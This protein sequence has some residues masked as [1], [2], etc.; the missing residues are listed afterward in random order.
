MVLLTLVVV[1][2][3]SL[4]GFTSIKI[5]K[6]L[7]NTNTYVN[8]ICITPSQAKPKPSQTQ[9]KPIQAKPSQAKAKDKAKAKAKAK[10][11]VKAKPKP[12]QKPSQSQTKAMPKAKPKPN[13]AKSSQSVNRGTLTCASRQSTSPCLLGIPALDRIARLSNRQLN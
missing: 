9:D 1:T 4:P 10:A 8:L 3:R 5:S 11:K 6:F 12:C 7:P 13:Q 2:E